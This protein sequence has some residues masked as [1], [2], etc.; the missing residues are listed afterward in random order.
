MKPNDIK[1]SEIIIIIHKSVKPCSRTTNETKA[2]VELG[3]MC[4][5]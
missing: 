5:Q 1:N 4:S 3:Y 2:T